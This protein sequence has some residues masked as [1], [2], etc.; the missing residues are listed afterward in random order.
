MTGGHAATQSRTLLIL[1]FDRSE[2]FTD[3]CN[4]VGKSGAQLNLLLIFFDT[5]VKLL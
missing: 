1:L 3:G 2:K 5:G 4:Q